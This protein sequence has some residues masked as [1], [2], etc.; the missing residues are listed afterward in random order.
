MLLLQWNADLHATD[1]E[2]NTPMHFLLHRHQGNSNRKYESQARR[3]I[4]LGANLFAEN[5]VSI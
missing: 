4:D 5:N 1:L 2:G 3:M